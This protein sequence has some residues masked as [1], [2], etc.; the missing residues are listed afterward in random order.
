MLDVNEPPG[1]KMET[2]P[3]LA[4]TPE[5]ELVK[6]PEPTIVLAAAERDKSTICPPD[7]APLAVFIEL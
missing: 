1:A 5:P 2:V 4:P 3:A 7:P 6:A